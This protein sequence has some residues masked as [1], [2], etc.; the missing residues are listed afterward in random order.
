MRLSAKRLWGKLKWRKTYA[1]IW[2]YLVIAGVGA[3][4]I[5]TVFLYILSSR[6]ILRNIGLHTESQLSQRAESLSFAMNWIV[7]YAQR[8]SQSP[9]V[10]AYALQ[11]QSTPFEDYNFWNLLVGMKDT[12]PYIDSIYVIN[13]YSGK[14]IDTRLGVSDTDAFYDREML[15]LL[16]RGRAED[17][18]FMAPRLVPSSNSLSSQERLLTIVIPFEL[19]KSATAFVV[20]VSSDAL[21][22]LNPRPS[23][24][25][26][27]DTYVLDRN[28]RI[29]A[30][31]RVADFLRPFS[32][33]NYSFSL[34]G[35]QGWFEY[36]AAADKLLV[37]HADVA[38]KGFTPWKIIDL[39]PERRLLGDIRYL[40]SF[41][42]LFFV[43]LLAATLWTIWKLSNKIY[44]PI[45]ELIMDVTAG[46]EAPD[47]GAGSNEL[48]YLSSVFSEQHRRIGDYSRNQKFLAKEAYLRS[49]LESA[50]VPGIEQVQLQFR[51]H[52]LRLAPDNV[53]IALLRIDHYHAFTLR[54]PERDRRLLRFAMGNIA[55]EHLQPLLHVEAVDMGGDHIALLFNPEQD[56]VPDSCKVAV[57]QCQE[58]IRQYLAI[59]TTAVVG[60]VA[61]NYRELHDGCKEAYELSNERFQSGWGQL[62]AAAETNRPAYTKLPYPKGKER[63]LIQ[64]LKKGD[65]AQ[66]LEELEAFRK[67]LQGNTHS[68]AKLAIAMLLLGI[69]EALHPLPLQSFRTAQWSLSPI[70]SR[71]EQL[72]TSGAVFDWLRELLLRLCED[73]AALH[74]PSRSTSLIE[75]MRQLVEEQLLDQNLSTKT[76]AD[77]LGLSV[78]YVRNL[79]KTETGQSLMDCIND[80]RLD[81][82]VELMGATAL[83]I[84]DIVMRCGFAS[85]VS[86]YPLFKKK[87]GV[88]PAKFRK[89]MATE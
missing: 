32:E 16:K 37:A 35:K 45:Q 3:L 54:Y 18:P 53:G 34:A 76:I 66:A 64:G 25:S 56:T 47:S 70:Q 2:T 72:E 19:E 65:A 83:S 6:T 71:I 23:A 29:V 67:L 63:L 22:Q 20:N 48:L 52:E 46:R 15:R 17:V 31:T 44:T 84:D 8:S 78:N 11:P 55:K 61:E 13:G 82:A 38:L 4:V 51:E 10:R 42:L 49:L 21:L 68:E 36:R 75:E 85:T 28:G 5:S 41:T 33:L 86:F 39:M 60:P 58:L 74:K 14:V 12:N 40:Q 87:F 9:A 62:F 79:F 7:D 30:S 89:D 77:Q 27:S 50:A 59:E 69:G 43:C 26:G 57:A 1:Q 88:T 81:R 73:V 80:R 24:P